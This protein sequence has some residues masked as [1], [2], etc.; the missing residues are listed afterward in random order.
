[1]SDEN[2]LLCVEECSNLLGI[3]RAT[4]WRWVRDGRLPQPISMG[5]LRRWR[6]SDITSFIN[7]RGPV[8]AVQPVAMA[9]PVAA[10]AASVTPLSA[11]A[12]PARSRSR[13]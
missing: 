2:R 7:G 5:R 9:A 6:K 11:A 3:S 10:P 12:R 1:M 13:G 4:V 8:V